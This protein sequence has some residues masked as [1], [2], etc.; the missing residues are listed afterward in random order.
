MYIRRASEKA[1]KEMVDSFKVIL[2]TGP[3]QVGKTTLIKDLLN[4]SYSY[5]TLDGM[6]LTTNP[7]PKSISS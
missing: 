6:D 1:L 4:K 7:I 5:V 3:R 2:V